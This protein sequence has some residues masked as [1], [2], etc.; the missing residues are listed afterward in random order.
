MISRELLPDEEAAE[1]WVVPVTK[2]GVLPIVNTSVPQWEKLKVR[3]ITRNQLQQLFSGK[4]PSTW[5]DISGTDD[6]TPIIPIMRSDESG[7][8]IIWAGYLGL[9]IS[10]MKGIESSGDTGVI[11]EVQ[12]HI[13]GLSFC[14]AH[15]AFD[16]VTKSQ[17]S[18]LKVLPIDMNKNGKIDEKEDFYQNLDD[19]HRAAYL[20]TYPS[21]L[22]R[23][24]QLVMK[25][26]PDDQSVK[27]FIKWVLTDG[28]EIAVKEGYCEL[29]KCDTKEAL[30]KLN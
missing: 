25:N 29:R 24:L 4:G 14:N 7:A 30:E 23:N 8:E 6:K 18:Y 26:K 21:A 22:C 1:L 2:E 17:V 13:G 20:G 3:G 10:E 11:T 27:A 28:Q 5:G 12:T 15:Y 16:P 9:N 19:I